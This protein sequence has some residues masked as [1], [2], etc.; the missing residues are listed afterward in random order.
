M[1]YTSWRDLL[2]VNDLEKCDSLRVV[3]LSGE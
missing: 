3:D 2:Y 1:D